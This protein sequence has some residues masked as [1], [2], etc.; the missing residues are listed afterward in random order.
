MDKLNLDTVKNTVKQFC[1]ERCSHST[2][3]VPAALT[4]LSIRQKL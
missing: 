3:T 4:T 2:W 1:W